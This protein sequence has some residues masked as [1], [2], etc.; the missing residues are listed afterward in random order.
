MHEKLV[1]LE[2][3]AQ[4][5]FEDAAFL[6]MLVKLRLVG[7]VRAAALIF[8]AIKRQI[9]RTDKHF[10]RTAIARAHG[11]ADRGTDI[12]RVLVDF[13]GFRQGIDNAARKPIELVVV[14]GIKHDD[15]KFVAAQTTAHV[16]A[17]H[18]RFETVG[19]ARQQPVANG[20]PKRVIDRFEPV[21]IDHHE[22]TFAAPAIRF[23]HGFA[24]CFGHLQAVGQAGQRVE[25][26]HV[27]DFVRRATLSRHVR[28]DAAETEKG[29]A[30]V[31]TR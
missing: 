13:I 29:S 25:P 23:G 1:V 27:I 9:G 2:R 19:N 15:G 12:K 18:H 5:D 17:F 24:E 28:P 14:A 26:R 6:G 21:E 3:L 7:V 11:S 10:D 16:A 22:R 8:R 30:V 20:M 31:V 4:R